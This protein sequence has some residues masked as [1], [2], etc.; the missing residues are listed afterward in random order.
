MSGNTV[1]RTMVAVSYLEIAAQGTDAQPADIRRA[2]DRVMEGYREAAKLFGDEQRARTVAAIA[3][4]YEWRQ[5][6]VAAFLESMNDAFAT[7]FEDIRD[8]VMRR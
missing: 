4:I 3:A 7:D 6:R 1:A 8:L 5:A 2:V